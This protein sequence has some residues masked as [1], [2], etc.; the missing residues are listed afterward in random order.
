MYNI[1]ASKE[2]LGCLEGKAGKFVFEIKYSVNVSQRMSKSSYPLPFT[3]LAAS[4]SDQQLPDQRPES[5]SWI[6]HTAR[7][8]CS[9]LHAYMK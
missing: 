5:V 3:G 8:T 6:I 7:S 4:G 9:L 2:Y 1:K